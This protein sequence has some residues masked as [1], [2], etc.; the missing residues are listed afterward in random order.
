MTTRMIG[1]VMT[2]L[3]VA[4]LIGTRGRANEGAAMSDASKAD[5]K[6]RLTAMQ[7]SVACE[8]STEPPFH[9]A[10]WDNHEPG[11]YVD[12]ISGAP[13]FSSANKFDSGTGW[14]SFTA[15]LDKSAVTNL[16]DDSLGMARTEVRAAGTGAHLGHVF[17]DGPAPGGMRYCINS[18]SLRFIP[19]KELAHAGYGRYQP[20]FA[21]VSSTGHRMT[22]TFSAGC[23]WGVQAAFDRVPGVTHTV[24][25][26]AGGTAEH[27]SYEQVCKGSTGHAESVE[28]TY[29][30]SRVTYKQLLDV[31]WKLGGEATGSGQYRSEIFYHDAQQQTLAMASLT[32]KRAQDS[33]IRTHLDAAGAFFPA[34][35][36]HQHYDAKHGV[37]GCAIP[38]EE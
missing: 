14:P 18:A 22:A 26:Y 5:L 33:D 34:E 35:E 37:S 19:L 1:L 36:Y 4:L 25:G 11:L 10:Y 3:S 7:Y 20:L 13:L 16:E 27:P 24:A 2:T 12:V 29:D 31:F 21:K 9:N 8:G 15:P 28:V 32:A 17:E 30:P 6:Q 23:F 38:K